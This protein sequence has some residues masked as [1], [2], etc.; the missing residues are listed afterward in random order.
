MDYIMKR[1]LLSSWNLVA[2]PNYGKD[3]Q[4]TNDTRD[5]DN[6]IL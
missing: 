6:F 4:F 1:A 3:V 2:R 5:Y